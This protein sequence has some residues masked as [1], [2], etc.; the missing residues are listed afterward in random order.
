MSNIQVIKSN[1]INLY[2]TFEYNQKNISFSIDDKNDFDNELIL[3]YMYQLPDFL[4][5][6][7][8]VGMTKC[9]L[10]ETFYHAISNRIYNQQH[11][12]ALSDN[13]YFLYG[14]KR[15]II[16]WG[17][18]I[19]TNNDSFKDYSIHEEILKEN[20]GIV[21][22][23]QE[24]F[25]N[26]PK[27]K[28]ISTFDKFRNKKIIKN[29]Y[30]PRNEQRECINSL[31]E[32]FKN[33]PTGR[34]LLNCK[35]RFGKSFTTYKYCEENNLDR[36]L[37]LTFVP[38]VESSW[39]EDLLHI[40]KNYRY[41]TDDNLK[42]SDFVLNLIQEPFVLFLSLQ[43]YLGKEKDNDVKNKIKQLQEIDWDVVIL[44]EYHFGAWNFKTLDT[45]KVKEEKS[46]D[47]D[48]EYQKELSKTNDIIKKFNIKT[49]QT[50]CLSGTP[51]KALAKGEFNDLSSYTYSYFDEQRNKYP[52]SES[53]NFEIIN[54][55]YEMFPDMQIFGYNMSR[56][57]SNL[58]ASVF[59]EDKFLS[60]KYFSLNKFF[61]T[62]KE[63]NLNEDCK[64]IYENE[65]K[66]WLE[67]IKGRSAFGDKFPY[68]NIKM[69]ENSMHTLWL[70][71]SVFSCCAMEKLLKD[72]EF[73]SRYHIINLSKEGVGSGIK[74]FE[75]L[76][77]N[78]TACKNQN[79]L[80]TIAITVNKLTIGVTVKKWSSIFVLKDLASPEQYFQ[81][82]FRIQTPYIE[83]NVIKKHIGYVYDFNIDRASAL[84]LKY[85]ELSASEKVTKLQIAKLIV[86]YMP[87]FINGDMYN[88][89]SEQVFYQLAEF[90]DSSGIPLSKKIIE[91]S[92]TTRLLDEETISEMLN[93]KEVSE[94]IKRVFAHAKFNKTKSKTVPSKP[95]DGFDS[96]IAK[97]GRDKGY[98]LGK[99]DCK[100]YIDYDD[101]NVQKEFELAIKKYV[102]EYCNSSYSEEQKLWY[103]NGFTKGYEAG[104]NAPIK[105]EKCGYDEGVKFSENIRNKFGSA[106]VYN[107]STKNMID[108]YVKEFLNNKN[109]ISKKY[110]GM[111]YYRWY[112]DSFKRAVKNSLSIKK[113]I[114]DGE[115]IEDTD[116]V[117]KHILARLF[118]FLYIS[119][120][121]ETNFMEIF[122]NADPD[123]FL[124]AVGITKK[125]FEVLNKYKI[126][127][128]DILN[129][130]IHDFFVNESLGSKLNLEDDEIK[131]NYRNSFNWFGFGIDK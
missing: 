14:L 97:E 60:K 30:I 34:F 105:K 50:I 118:E 45:I 95:D 8:K 58:T 104:V 36:I 130:Y 31:S 86:K 127:Q 63:N 20:I 3:I 57:F 93:D 41:F 94:I 49:R 28:L 37:I 44:D 33:N 77:D 115:T 5:H 29:I 122:N 74:A 64:F 68:S 103:I 72:D 109:N 88:P 65:I 87:I 17:I 117:L 12:L 112:C 128:E 121:R 79:K 18:C 70:M 38:A 71:P 82:I 4:S 54:K 123:T 6:G 125:D 10:G 131:K 111:L 126:F 25:I 59:S 52:E 56:L 35:M 27:E 55:D 39:K 76:I 62:R 23:E 13:D 61:E 129:N 19:D 69:L 85:A 16:Y 92:K 22:K 110:H 43:N 42:R 21:E 114:K 75:Y 113:E 107:L 24:W 9:K 53:G 73:F 11:E 78:M 116:N 1:S 99:E 48:I 119:V 120:Y 67:I 81:A 91:T 51:F 15:E 2:D 46:E 32:Y 102:S 101:L 89:I 66:S 26:I 40:N 90:G 98:I 96:L 108:N 124:E 83:N 80:G 100:K 84:L 47:L 7:I 106:I